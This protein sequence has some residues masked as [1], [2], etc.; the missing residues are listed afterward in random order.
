MHISESCQKDMTYYFQYA[1]RS[2][3]PCIV[4]HKHS[5][6]LTLS[7]MLTDIEDHQ[8]LIKTN[9][10]KDQQRLEELQRISSTDTFKLLI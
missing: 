6:M 7:S 9:E 4:Y 5:F 2:T 1:S 3:V 8:S 10:E